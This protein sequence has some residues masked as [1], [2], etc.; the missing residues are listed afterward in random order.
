M[1]LSGLI[2]DWMTEL[3]PGMAEVVRLGEAFQRA[4]A[5][6]REKI[7]RGVTAAYESVRPVLEEE[8]SRFSETVS[9]MVD[10]DPRTCNT[11]VR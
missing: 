5:E 2:A 1:S 3:E 8:S 6:H 10:G 11:G 9:E 7:L 4:N